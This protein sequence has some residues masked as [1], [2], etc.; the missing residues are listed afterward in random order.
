MRGGTKKEGQSTFSSLADL[1]PCVAIYQIL[2]SSSSSGMGGVAWRFPNV[3]AFNE[4]SPRPR[5]ARAQ[6]TF[7]S[8]LSKLLSSIESRLILLVSLGRSDRVA[9]Y[10][11]HRT[12][13]FLSCAF[14]E[15]EGH[16]AAP[17]PLLLLDC[18]EQPLPIRGFHEG[19]DLA[20]FRRN[21]LAACHDIA[22]LSPLLLQRQIIVPGTPA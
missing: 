6:E 8:F 17:P 18:P 4:R 3:R 10:C 21:L 16:L 1:C 19:P 15:Q 14:C 13:T 11:A 2:L 9:L 7:D 12:S 20:G 22:W 5:V